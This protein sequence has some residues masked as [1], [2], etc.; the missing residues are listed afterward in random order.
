MA[1]NVAYYDNADFAVLREAWPDS[2]SEQDA[3]LRCLPPPS[4]ILHPR[5]GFAECIFDDVTSRTLE[6]PWGQRW[7]HV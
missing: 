2:R 7:F 4:W 1:L 3:L 6:T 5:I